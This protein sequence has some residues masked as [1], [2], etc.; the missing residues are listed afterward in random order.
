[1]NDFDDLPKDGAPTR[2]DVDLVKLDKEHPGFRDPLYRARRNDIARAALNWRFGQPVPEI[3]Y[4]PEENAVWK[5]ALANLSPLHAKYACREF[6]ECWPELKFKPDRIPEFSE[7]NGTIVPLTGMHLVPVAGLVTPRVFF[8]ELGQ[9][10]FL[11]T[12]YIRHG[13]AP[14]YTPEPDVIHELVGH[15][16][17]LAHPEF[18]RVNR[19]FGEVAAKADEAT[20]QKLIRVYWYTLEFGVV[21][22]PRGLEVVG[23]GLLSSYGEL[24]RFE[25]KATLLPFDLEKVAATPFDPTDYQGT[26]F[27]A[28]S[29]EALLS[30]LNDWLD[31]L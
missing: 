27:V 17:L 22:S 16:A 4:T 10:L 18:A 8:V 28:E 20:V 2:G 1:M 11:G 31:V 23:A 12:Q 5:T 13:S 6:K 24:G 7:L 30:E 26:L 19:R 21:K 29:A 25:Q 15:A 9:G 3:A 14:L